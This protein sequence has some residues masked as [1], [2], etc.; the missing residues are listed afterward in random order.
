MH[1]AGHRV[2]VH[3]VSDCEI[4]FQARRH[5]D[6]PHN[7]D[8]NLNKKYVHRSHP[9]RS[10][11]CLLET[12]TKQS[13]G[14]GRR[15][16]EPSA[17]GRHVPV[18]HRRGCGRPCGARGAAVHHG[19][20]RQPQ[21]AAEGGGHHRLRL[22]PGRAE[23]GHHARAGRQA[24][25]PSSW[26]TCA[27]ATSWSRTRRRGPSAASATC[28]RRPP[29]TL[30]D[31]LIAAFMA[32]LNDV[33]SVAGNVCWA[34]HNLAN[35][36]PA[37]RRQQQR[38]DQVLHRPAARCS[39]QSRSGPTPT[40][41]TCCQSAYEAINALISNGGARVVPHHPGAH[42][43]PPV[44]QLDSTM[45]SNALS[46]SERERQNEVQALLCGAC[47]TIIQKLEESA[48]LTHADAFMTLFIRVLSSKN[49]T[50]HEEALMA[51]GALA[52]RVHE[53]FDKYLTA[54]SPFLF[55]GLRNEKEY[56]VCTVAVGLVG[57]I[58]SCSGRQVHP[59][60]R[61]GDE[62]AAAAP[63]SLP[64]SSAPSSR[65]S[66]P[67]WATSR[68]P[69]AA[70]SCATSP[71]CSASSSPPASSSSR[72]RTTTTT[73]STTW[74][75]CASPSSSR[76]P[77]SCRGS[78]RPTTA[79]RLPAAHPAGEHAAAHLPAGAYPPLLRQLIAT[80]EHVRRARHPR[81]LR[82]HRRPVLHVRQQGQGPT[83][84]N[85]AVERPHPGRTH[86]GHGPEHQAAGQV[87]Q[88]GVHQTHTRSVNP[89]TQPTA[90]HALLPP[91]PPPPPPP[92]SFRLPLPRLPP[93]SPS[94]VPSSSSSPPLRRCP[95]PPPPRPP[96][97]KAGCLP[98]PCFCPSAA[99][100]C[101]HPSSSCTSSLRLSLHHRPLFN[102][103][104]AF[105]AN[106]DRDA[107]ST[108]QHSSG[109]E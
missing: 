51:I 101:I 78:V 75:S 49:A 44:T 106:D 26:R 34:I 94:L 11:R 13:G 99:L 3:P 8:P 89:H 5:M 69:W 58:S 66:S 108:A 76:G 24:P 39:S 6:D 85:P 67:A 57:D 43:R 14:R 63:V 47:Q 27:T 41:T 23:G 40:S 45:T 10:C 36:L 16:V 48:I 81:G 29:R 30:L 15:D 32:G 28:T 71:S 55:T 70:T 4:V 86:A 59:A 82:P 56:K 53:Q 17:G 65:T 46:P 102:G 37:G 33:P 68:W 107:P 31:K 64:P 72:R 35:A 83:S 84:R 19:E 22:H 38:A 20:H 18:P 103:S 60:Q 80:D 92:P 61:R 52:N 100:Q 2:L 96:S 74:T 90:P 25:S 98:P 54:L 50:V 12:L 9:R 79:G 87:G 42:P 104:T 105:P 1:A 21:L 93:S 97:L 62:G 109:T 88:G 95:L 73:T 91:P 7:T 77:A